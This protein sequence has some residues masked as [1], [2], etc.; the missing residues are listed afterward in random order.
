MDPKTHNQFFM[1]LNPR[2]YLDS[3]L[4]AIIG[5]FKFDVHQKAQYNAGIPPMKKNALYLFVNDVINE[6]QKERTIMVT[7]F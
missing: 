3:N 6:F 4:V 7:D 1:E 2:K 5:V